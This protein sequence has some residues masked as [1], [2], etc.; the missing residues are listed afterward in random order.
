M[1][2]F[3]HNRFDLLSEWISRTLGSPVSFMAACALVTIWGLSGPIFGF[4]DTWQLVI[5]TGTTIATFLMVFLLQNTGNRTIAEM[6]DHLH[7]L[8]RQNGELLRELRAQRG[9]VDLPVAR[10]AA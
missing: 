4:S 5:N 2:T 8:E 7:R 1:K 6:Q 10:E 3:I 9:I